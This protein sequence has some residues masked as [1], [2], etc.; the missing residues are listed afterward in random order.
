MGYSSHLCISP[1][2][3]KR[4]RTAQLCMSPLTVYDIFPIS[5]SFQSFRNDFF[6][7]LSAWGILLDLKFDCPNAISNIFKIQ[8][9]D[10]RD[11]S[12]F[13][14]LGCVYKNCLLRFLP[15]FLWVRDLPLDQGYDFQHWMTRTVTVC[16]NAT[17]LDSL[18]EPL[19]TKALIRAF[20][21]DR[22]VPILPIGHAANKQTK[23]D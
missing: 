8:H 9:M 2:A 13:L 19:K 23:K 12:K 16:I 3:I 20:G 17:A 10:S 22:Y 6:R 5:L 1:Q 15:N 18:T 4:H 21:Q 7:R 14:R 11:L